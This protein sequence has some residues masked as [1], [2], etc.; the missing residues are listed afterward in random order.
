MIILPDG[1]F[2]MGSPVT[3]PGHQRDEELATKVNVRSFGL[4]QT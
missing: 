3:E 2:T 4:C 1:E